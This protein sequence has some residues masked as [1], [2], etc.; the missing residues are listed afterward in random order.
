MKILIADDD[1]V[2]RRLLRVTLERWGYEVVSAEDG[3]RAWRV[4]QETEIHLVIADWMMPQLNGLELCRRIRQ[5]HLG[6]YVYVILLT[7]LN[8]KRDVVE[9]LAAGADDYVVKPFDPDELR[10]RIQAGE[11]VISLEQR[12]RQ[13]HR[14]MEKLATIDGLTGLLNRRAAMKRLEEE[15]ARARREGHTLSCL[16][17]DLDRFKSINDSYGHSTGDEVLQQVADRMSS[18]CRP[19]DI[20]GR[21]GGEEFLA[22]LVGAALEQAVEIAG[23][24][25]HSISAEPVEWEGISVNVKASFGVAEISNR[26]EESPESLIIRADRA[27]YKAKEEGGNRVC[28]I[29][30]E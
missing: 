17:L 29:G 27:L 8:S 25:R 10:V 4:L 24:F 7:V 13:A 26:A 21:Y 6:S 23:R 5:A 3:D 11:R 9:G 2:S 18:L 19:Y 14:D 30:R 20:L 1:A 12:L 16:I 15:F 28:A 22:V